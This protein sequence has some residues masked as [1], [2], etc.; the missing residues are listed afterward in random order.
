MQRISEMSDAKIEVKIAISRDR[1]EITR[2]AGEMASL[3]GEI[4]DLTTEQ[5]KR[6]NIRKMQ[7]E[8]AAR[9][10]VIE[11]VAIDFKSRPIG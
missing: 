8:A 2:D 1:L 3:T 5:L 10:I 9:G 6:A 7:A 4:I 11:T